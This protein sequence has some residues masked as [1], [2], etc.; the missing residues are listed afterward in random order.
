MHVMPSVLGHWY[1]LEVMAVTMCVRIAAKP[2]NSLT[3]VMIYT[4]YEMVLKGNNYCK[5]NL[6][7][8]IKQSL[9]KIKKK[10]NLR[11]A[12]NA[13]RQKC[14]PTRSYQY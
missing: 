6:Y 13:K 11:N 8:C 1:F 4:K 10:L 7:Y 12:R 3:T 2:L 5:S 9:E 14:V